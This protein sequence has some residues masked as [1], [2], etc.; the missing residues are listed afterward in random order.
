MK[1]TIIISALSCLVLAASCHKPE[2]VEPTVQR[3]SITSI[4]AFFTDG[5]YNGL[6]LGRLEVEDPDV[7]RFVI[8]IPYYYPEES[9]DQTTIYMAKVR[10]KAEL[11]ND[12]RIDPPLTVM[13]LYDE[14]QFTFTDASGKSRKIVITGKRVKSSNATLMSFSIVNPPVEGFIDNDERKV[15]LFTT[16]DLSSVS[17]T[18]VA[19]AHASVKSELDKPADYNNPRE[20][21]ILAPDGKTEIVYTVEKAIPTKIAHG[22]NKSSVRQLFNFAPESRLGTPAYT[23][24]TNPSLAAIGGYLVVCMGDGSTPIYLDGQ[25]G[26][27]KGEIALGSAV[28][29]SIASDEAGNMLICNHIADDPYSGSLKLYKSSSVSEAPVLFCEYESATALPRGG[30]M[31]VSG[32]LDADAM[33]T[34]LFEG[35]PNVT[36]AS[37]FISI[38]V[39]GGKVAS[40]NEYDLAPAGLS[41]GHAPVNAAALA[42]ASSSAAGGWFFG[43]Y[44]GISGGPELDWIRPDCTLG[45]NLP[46]SAGLGWAWNA[47]QIDCKAYNNAQYLAFFVLSHFPA[48][49]VAP[50][51]LVYDVSDISGLKGEFDNCSALVLGSELE[52]FQQT[53]AEDTNSC[54]DVVIAPSADG[55]KLFIYYFDQYAG[56]IGGFVAD[57][58]KK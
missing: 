46:T 45:S 41:W 1:K 38:E 28:P 27:K 36:S 30:K 25:T 48:W 13:S 37:K 51:L 11:A 3:Q 8:P 33:I 40:V 56:V 57:C 12:C 14:N 2:Y 55:F 23:A 49:G 26:A 7:D 5:P 16:D 15:F 53:N 44:A 17:A 22:F 6:L 20:I 42:P 31:E 35:V 43:A 24:A 52:Y 9:D 50:Q 18:A 58:I 10:V 47:N 32:N 29:G 54:G 4:S 34:I 19:S 39:I 21:V